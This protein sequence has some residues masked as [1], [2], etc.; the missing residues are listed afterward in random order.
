MSNRDTV[1]TE[2]ATVG[3]MPTLSESGRRLSAMRIADPIV[4]TTEV[5]NA[6]RKADGDVPAASEAL[7]VS[8]RTLFRWIEDNASLTTG[9]DLRKAGRPWPEKP[10]KKR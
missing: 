3:R 6:L 2:R 1:G 8:S 4:W 7:G 9:I 5:R 10:V